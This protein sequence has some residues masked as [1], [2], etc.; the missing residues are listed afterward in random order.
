MA[1]KYLTH[2][3]TEGDTIQAI[4]ARYNVDWTQV[5][6]LNGLEYPYIDSDLTDDYYQ[7]VDTVAKVGTRLLIP[8]P[9]LVV[10]IKDNSNDEVIEEYAFGRDLDLFSEIMT[11]AGV[12]NLE[13]TGWLTDENRDIK[14]C[15]GI[16]NLRQ[17]LV[18]RLGTPK[19]AL[20]LHPEFGSNITQF[21]GRKVTPELLTEVKL[22]VQECL[23]TDFRVDAV[24]GITARFSDRSISI[25]C[26]VH[27]I[28]PYASPFLLGYTFVD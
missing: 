1:A 23:L 4:G 21:I 10:P 15:K 14:Q 9:G 28:E 18:I 19:G 26:K 5:V 22:E 16:A 6:E 20:L 17:Q 11:P 12:I 2:T 13:D 27:P 25:S 7:F 24:S 8:T 3:V